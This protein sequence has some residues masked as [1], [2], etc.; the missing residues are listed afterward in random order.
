MGSVPFKSRQDQLIKRLNNKHRQVIYDKWKYEI[1]NREIIQCDII[2]D[3]M[4]E[5]NTSSG[6]NNNAI[7]RKTDRSLHG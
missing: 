7:E 3:N 1:E 4:E 6:F 5:I 2:F